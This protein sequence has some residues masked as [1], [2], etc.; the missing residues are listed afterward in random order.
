MGYQRYQDVPNDPDP[1]YFDEWGDASWWRLSEICKRNKV[2]MFSGNIVVDINPKTYFL[3]VNYT[4]E[5]KY[6]N[7][8]VFSYNENGVL[9]SY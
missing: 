7:K 3:E 4:T 6:A 1:R 5:A 9:K 8:L 2:R